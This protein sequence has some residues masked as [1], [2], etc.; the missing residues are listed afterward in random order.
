M[1]FFL[2]I[3]NSKTY[4]RDRVME[5]YEGLFSFTEQRNV[6]YVIAN[7]LQWQL[8]TQNMQIYIKHAILKREMIYG[9][10]CYYLL[11]FLF[12]MKM[13]L[14]MSNGPLF[15]AI[16]NIV[17]RILENWNFLDNKIKF[18]SRKIVH[19]SQI[20]CGFLV[21]LQHFGTILYYISV[22]L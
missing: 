20:N 6:F 9:V 4:G 19:F 17:K 11:N 1:Y 2:L 15:Y 13:E 22:F 3:K 21:M 12:E 16:Y 14:N 7:A 8:D 5:Y 18:H 10:F